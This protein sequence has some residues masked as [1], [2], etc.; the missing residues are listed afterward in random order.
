MQ[1]VRR[2][3]SFMMRQGVGRKHTRPPVSAHVSRCLS[4]VM[5]VMCGLDRQRARTYAHTRIHTCLLAC[6]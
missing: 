5:S 2:A 1:V 4:G 3:S 6:S